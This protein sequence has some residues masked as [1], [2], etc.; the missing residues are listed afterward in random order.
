[1]ASLFGGAPKMPP[2]QQI[3]KPP[4]LDQAAQN[5]DQN[6]MLRRRRGR[7]ADILTGTKGDLV[8]PNIGT[9]TLLGQ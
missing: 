4:T 2:P 9:A 8:A 5:A 7:A 1:M 3:P 6:D